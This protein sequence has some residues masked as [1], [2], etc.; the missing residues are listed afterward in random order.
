MGAL[1]LAFLVTGCFQHHCP[2]TPL[3]LAGPVDACCGERGVCI[4][5]GWGCLFIWRLSR[6]N[7]QQFD[8][9]RA[10]VCAMSLGEGNNLIFVIRLLQILSSVC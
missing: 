3:P 4:D 9:V 6:L 10:Q 1:F 2:E 8:F 7:K 5:G